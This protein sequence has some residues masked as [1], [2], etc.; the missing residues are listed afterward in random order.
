[1]LIAYFA[2]PLQSELE[3]IIKKDLWEK[4]SS[5]SEKLNLVKMD[6]VH[7]DSFMRKRSVICVLRQMLKE[8]KKIGEIKVKELS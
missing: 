4:P 3:T 7:V 2:K 6:E 8:T 5:K 1:V